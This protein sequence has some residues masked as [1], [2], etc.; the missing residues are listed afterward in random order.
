MVQENKIKPIKEEIPISTEVLEPIS[1]RIVLSTSRTAEFD[2][3]FTMPKNAARVHYYGGSGPSRAYS[4]TVFYQDSEKM[5]ISSNQ[6]G[7]RMNTSGSLY[8]NAK[9]NWGFTYDF[10]TKKVK[11]WFGNKVHLNKIVVKG[12]S[13]NFINLDWLEDIRAFT[14]DLAE[15][16][17]LLGHVLSGKITNGRDLI[18]KYLKTNA[19]GIKLSPEI[20]YKYVKN[21]PAMGSMKWYIARARYCKNP[22]LLFTENEHTCDGDSSFEDT[23][24]QARQLNKLI[25]LK[26]SEKK[27]NEM[28]KLW[29]REIMAIHFEGVP[30]FTVEYEGVCPGF[31][32]FELVNI[33]KELFAIGSIEDHCVYTNYW[34]K[35]ENKTYFVLYGSYEGKNYTCGITRQRVPRPVL[36]TSEGYSEYADG[37]TYDDLFMIDQIQCRRNQG[38]PAELKE[39][40]A[41]WLKDAGVQSFFNLNW[42]NPKAR[43]P[44]L[45]T[46]GLHDLPF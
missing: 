17:A 3:W 8:L 24:K 27:L 11:R 37:K 4:E 36:H 20:V 9:S 42:N 7:I 16:S 32:G 35:V 34:Y 10:K 33:Q 31:A 39:S 13:E 25:D 2:T 29:T 22:D 6:V 30:N 12:I 23:V 41:K 5:C 18:K 40:I 45:T 15:S 21:N 44:E 46:S 28:H 26:W 14:S 1:K 19:R 38:C 43:A